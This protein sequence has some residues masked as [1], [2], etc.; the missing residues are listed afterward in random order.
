[1]IVVVLL[2]VMRMVVMVAVVVLMSMF[3][4]TVVVALMM[5]VMILVLRTMLVVMIVKDTGDCPTYQELL[6]QHQD[7][8]YSGPKDANLC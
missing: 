1:M 5:A 3:V 2:V 6:T 8:T 7:S 4:L